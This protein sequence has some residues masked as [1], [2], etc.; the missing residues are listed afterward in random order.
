M[1]MIF[2][3][4]LPFRAKRAIAPSRSLSLAVGNHCYTHLNPG[5]A[6]DYSLE[7]KIWKQDTWKQENISE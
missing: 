5:R 7:R 2:R 3:S 6:A 4:L 1:D